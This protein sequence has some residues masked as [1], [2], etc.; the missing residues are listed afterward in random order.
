KKS[1]YYFELPF[2]QGVDKNNIKKND[3][4]VQQYAQMGAYIVQNCQLLIALWNGINDNLQGG[5]SFIVNFQINGIPEDYKKDNNP[6]SN[7]ET[8][9]VYHI[10]TPRK[11]DNSIPNDIS[12]AQYIYPNFWRKDIQ[13]R[14]KVNKF[15]NV[16]P[17]INKSASKYYDNLFKRFNNLNQ[18]VFRNTKYLSK[19]SHKSKEQLINLETAKYSNENLEIVTN[20]F[21]IFDTLALKFKKKRDFALRLIL[22]LIV[23]SV[24]C[25]QMYLEFIKHPLV[26]FF[27]PLSLVFSI[28]LYKLVKFFEYDK[29]HEDYRSIAESLRVHFYWSFSGVLDNVLDHYLHKHRGEL[30]WI[31]KCIRNIQIVSNSDF[32]Y[33]NI[34]DSL[35]INQINLTLKYW[36]KSQADWFFVNGNY[37]YL[38]SKSYDRYSLVFFALG[39]INSF[40]L[41]FLSIFFNITDIIA[42]VTVGGLH[43]F[44]VVSIG[45]SIAMFA[46]LKG[47]QDKMVFSEL[48]KQ[49]IRM[50]NLYKSA[51]KAIEKH[52]D[53]FDQN[54]TYQILTKVGEEALIENA[55]WILK[56]R[57][58]SIE[59]PYG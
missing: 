53:A 12:S 1:E 56:H 39:L 6:F 19:T 5:T 28:T 41:L 3:C 27:Y 11:K 8:G 22:L 47:Y 9:P 36:I 7:I 40:L 38:K 58:H 51:N 15:I 50:S 16:E 35:K 17:E 37:F 21:S 32:D 33:K 55:D 4:R 20:Y 34:V 23:L 59:L 49:Y 42:G 57:S 43:H 29:K 24:L 52:L 2:V 26:L 13:N 10:L 25:F 46:V 54:N 18:D 30:E 14:L 44:L 31:R 45:L 48:S